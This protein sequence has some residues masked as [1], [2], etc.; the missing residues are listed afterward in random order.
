VARFSARCSCQMPEIR[1]IV[2]EKGALQNVPSLTILEASSFQ[3]STA[4]GPKIVRGGTLRKRTGRR[5]RTSEHHQVPSF[6]LFEPVVESRGALGPINAKGGSS[7]SVALRGVGVHSGAFSEARRENGND[8][9]S[10]FG[11]RRDCL[12]VPQA[13]TDKKWPP[14]GA[15]EV[16]VIVM[17]EFTFQSPRPGPPVWL[18]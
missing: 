17:K 12:S 14:R 11:L 18:P 2:G 9:A 15:A 8:P 1:F 4:R 10:S 6:A 13:R 7:Y 5:A 16:E 3:L